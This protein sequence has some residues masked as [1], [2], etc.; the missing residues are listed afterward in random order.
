MKSRWVVV[1]ILA[2]VAVV[3]TAVGAVDKLYAQ[4]ERDKRVTVLACSPSGFPP[5][6][7]V[8]AYSPSPGSPV[9]GRGTQCA[10]GLALLLDDGFHI[11]VTETIAGSNFAILTYT[12]VESKNSIIH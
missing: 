3:L 4:Q 7:T 2:V 12:M 6:L 1:A 9:I 8:Y 11:G 10:A 5:E